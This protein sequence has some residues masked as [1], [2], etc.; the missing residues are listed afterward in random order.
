MNAG[1]VRR[2]YMFTHRAL[3]GVI[4]FAVLAGGVTGAVITGMV[5]SEGHPASGVITED[6]PRWDCAT[7]GN[8]VCGTSPVDLTD[9]FTRCLEAMEAAEI[10]AWMWECREHRPTVTAPQ[11]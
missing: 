3:T 8:R 7:M 2:M 11:G 1:R 5:A 6:D 4:M 10:P 9:P